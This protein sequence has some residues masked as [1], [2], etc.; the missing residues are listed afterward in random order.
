M[1]AWDSAS[2]SI[3]DE[4]Q[5]GKPCGKACSAA[6]HQYRYGHQKMIAGIDPVSRLRSHSMTTPPS[7]R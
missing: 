2:T 7:L 6:L 3:P 4:E 1:M 5:I